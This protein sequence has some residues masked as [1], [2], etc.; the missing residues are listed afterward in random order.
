M[1]III[2]L[3]ASFSNQRYLASFHM[4]LSDS[5]SPKVTRILLSILANPNTPVV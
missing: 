4:R 2:I 5:E 1:F 3:L